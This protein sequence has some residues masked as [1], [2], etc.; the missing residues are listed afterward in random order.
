A[1]PTPMPPT[2]RGPRPLPVGTTSLVGREQAIDEVAG[3]VGRPD[4]RLVTLTGPGGVGKTRLAVAVGERLRQHFSAG[5]AFVPL[6]TVTRPEPVLASIGRAV[7]A[8]LAGTGSPLEALVEQFGAGAWLLILDNLEQVADAA[9]DINELLTRCPGVAILATS[10][11]AL[12]LRA[13]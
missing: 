5:T 8:E 1:N 7:G 12:R 2:R 6:A 4:A 11:T 9:R 10:L 13:E 3:L